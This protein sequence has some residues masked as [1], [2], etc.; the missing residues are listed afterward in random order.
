MVQGVLVFLLVSGLAAMHVLGGGTRLVFSIP[1]YALIGVASLLAAVLPGRIR[2]LG[3]PW[4]LY[5]VVALA[6]YVLIRASLSP[7]E[8]LSRFHV[9]ATL[10]ALAVYLLMST[11][12]TGQGVRLWVIAGLLAICLP[13]L[14]YGAIQFTTWGREVHVPG[15]IPPN[16]EWRASGMLMCPTHLGNFMAMMTLLAAGVTLWARIGWATRILFGYMTLVCLGGTVI[17]GSRGPYLA[18]AC[19]AALFA[20]L[21]IASVKTVHRGKAIWLSLGVVALVVG[22]LGA[23]VQYIQSKPE[24][25][26]RL[27]N[28]FEMKNMRFEMWEAA[29]VPWFDKPWF[30]TGSW[31]FLYYGR[32]FRPFGGYQKD[33]IHVH[34]DFVHTLAEYGIVGLFLLVLVIV[35]HV[36]SGWD[37][38]K[39]LLRK[40]L[41]P[42]MRRTSTTLAL[43]IGGLSALGVFTTHAVVDFNMHIPANLL[44]ITIVMGILANPAA[45]EFQR[46]SGSHLVFAWMIRVGLLVLGVVLL[47]MSAQHW[48]AEYHAERARLAVRDGHWAE[49]VSQAKAGLAQDDS[50]PALH[51]Y[52]GKA[53]LNQGSA[54]EESSPQL[55]QIFYEGAAKSLEKGLELF[56]YDVWGQL[57]YAQ[58]LDFAGKPVAARAAY[59]RAIELDPNSGQP[60][61]WLGLHYEYLGQRKL[62]ITYYQ[63]ALACGAGGS[64]FAAQ[65][66][67]GLR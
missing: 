47:A 66:L 53:R 14:Y 1:A 56:P 25:S 19:G 24:M 48:Q 52:L 44:T 4:C 8:Y 23:A 16:Y 37:T 20:F 49:A 41:E 26:K 31:T 30:G 3:R 60:Y 2:S 15:I 62:A 40:R 36:G 12:V 54:L 42:S 67:R 27:M 11:K 33:P 9:Y 35:L 45:G 39:W 61:E 64:Q 34:N 13:H 22:A 6:A 21:T 7:V 43:M 5:A 63:K 28:V 32:M 38:S 50:I 29:L 59:R 46:E 57:D 58:A 18:I 17:A 10:G 65:R 55:A 51:H